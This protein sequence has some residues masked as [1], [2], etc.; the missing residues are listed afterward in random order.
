MG[1]ISGSC[2]V[3]EEGKEVQSKGGGG[4][5]G[6]RVRDDG[7]A[8]RFGTDSDD[9]AFLCVKSLKLAKQ[10][11][12]AK[13]FSAA[14]VSRWRRRRALSSPWH[15]GRRS[16]PNPPLS[17]KTRAEKGREEP[18]PAPPPAESPGPDHSAQKSWLCLQSSRRS[19]SL[20]S[21]SYLPTMSISACFSFSEWNLSDVSA[22]ACFQDTQ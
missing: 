22:W 14:T 4:G 6:G 3:L 18:P 11:E 9:G 19:T 21:M 1:E 17:P 20:L 16:A 15:T 2:L 10:N 5:G 12:E 13:Q 8:K 7:R